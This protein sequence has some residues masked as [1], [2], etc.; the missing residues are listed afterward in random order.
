MRRTGSSAAALL[1]A[2][3]LGGCGGNRGAPSPPPAPSPTPAAGPSPAAG[4]NAAP[5]DRDLAL[6]TFDSAWARIERTHY[7]STFRGVDWYAVRDE[8]RPRAASAGTLGGLRT[9]ITEML[10]RLGES[11]YALIPR[12]VADAVGDGGS[13]GGGDIGVEL[14]LAGRELVVARIDPGSPAAAAGIRPGWRVDSIAERATDG[15]LENLRELE[16]QPE[17]RLA[18]TQFLWSSNGALDGSPGSTVRLVLRDGTGE[19]HVV[20]PVRRTPPGETVQF[21]NLPPM[22]TELTQNRLEVNGACVGLIRFNVWMVPIG[23]AFDRAMDGMRDCTGIII[24][25]RGNPGGVAGMVMGV[26]GH[27]LDER[28]PLGV[29]RQRTG[30]L[31]LVANPRRVDAQGNPVTPFAGPV[32]V[33]IDP[34]SVS[35]SEIF[36]AGMQ[37]AGRVRVFGETSAGQALPATAVRLPNDDVLMH[38][39][40]DLTVPDGTRVE[41]RGV[42]PDV[43]IPLRREDLLAGRDAALEAAVGWIVSPRT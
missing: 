21:G 5:I 38:V 4:P 37:A 12:E 35:T 22:V 23:P 24:D 1:V 14:R 17:Y 6:T 43:S 10:G 20:E 26:A 3:L 13:R 32:A 9:V 7:D 33:L 11:H 29:L 25:L 30:E 42:V 41:G 8:M 2:I 34:L 18:L 27:F 16:G 31:R 36:A 15:P 40:A 28:V 39:I 19:R